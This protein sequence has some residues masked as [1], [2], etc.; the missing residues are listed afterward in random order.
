L[1]FSSHGVSFYKRIKNLKL[2]WIAG[3]FVFL[4]NMPFGYWR[5]RVPKFSLQWVLAVHMPVPFVILCRIFLGLGWQLSTFP[6][7]VGA[8]F[9][10]QFAGGKLPRLLGSI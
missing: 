10:G 7:L 4:L 1:L 2:L 3:I 5:S 9:A 8:F 6:I